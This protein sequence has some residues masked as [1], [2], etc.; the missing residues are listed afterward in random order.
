MK[1]AAPKYPRQPTGPSGVGGAGVRRIQDTGGMY[2]RNR[3]DANTLSIRTGDFS[4]VIIDGV[5]EYLTFA[6]VGGEYVVRETLNHRQSFRNSIASKNVTSV[7]AYGAD[8]LYVSES[9]SD[10]QIQSLGYIY[11]VYPGHTETIFFDRE[12]FRLHFYFGKYRSRGI[13]IASY[14]VYY[15]YL[16]LTAGNFMFFK[17]GDDVSYWGKH[18]DK[19]RS[20][21]SLSIARLGRTQ[22]S[23]GRPLADLTLIRHWANDENILEEYPLDPSDFTW[24]EAE[25]MWITRQVV[26]KDYTVGIFAETFFR[27][28]PVVGG[29]DYTPKFWAVTTPNTSSFGQFQYTNLTPSVFS[30]ALQPT[31]NPTPVAHYGTTSGRAYQFALSSTMASMEIAVVDYDA[32]VISWQQRM[33]GGWRTRVA[34]FVVSSGSVSSTMVYESADIASRTS[35]EYW[36]SVCHLGDG[37]VLAK[38]VSGFPGSNRNVVF[39]RSMDGGSSWGPTFSPTGFNTILRNEYFGDFIANKATTE[40]EPGRVLIPA[41]DASNS[42]YYVWASDDHGSSW[43]RVGKIYKPASFIRVDSMIVGDGGGNFEF[44]AP[45]PVLSNKLDVTLPDRY[46][47]RS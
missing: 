40:D 1:K 33:T 14:L 39:R 28:G 16:P 18:P 27:P 43:K 47:E 4:K 31:Q 17:S 8:G 34:R 15:M 24:A 20:T 6:N 30:G 25:F 32:F 21:I 23:S 19:G 13:E 5:P 9:D 35:L 22:A 44:L 38:I 41:W 26:L 42:T 46:K 3:P 37:V 2:Q 29:T 11:E 12:I 10:Y 45:G 7:R 36:Q